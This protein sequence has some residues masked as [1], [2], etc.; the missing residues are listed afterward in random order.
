MLDPRFV[1]RG[2]S[3][4][5][6]QEKARMR[7]GGAPRKAHVSASSGLTGGHTSLPRLA[8][9]EA[10]DAALQP[11]GKGVWSNAYCAVSP[12]QGESVA[13]SHRTPLVALQ[14]RRIRR[15]PHTHYQRDPV[16]RGRLLRHKERGECT[17]SRELMN[18]GY[19]WDRVC[20]RWRSP[21][22]KRAQPAA[23]AAPGG[24]VMG[25][26]S[27]GETP[28]HGRSPGGRLGW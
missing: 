4:F 18:A 16:R 25:T 26:R 9:T 3:A 14:A 6:W 27:L 5:S 24:P 7:S 2:M 19:R 22:H 1:Q 12:A 13:E 15:R 10:L 20:G 28:S 17:E 23:Q 21:L 8:D 11:M